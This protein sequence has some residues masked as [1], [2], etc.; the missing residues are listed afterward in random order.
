LT[1]SYPTA[2]DTW[3]VALVVAALVVPWILIL[4]DDDVQPVPTSM[5]L[6]LGGTTVLVVA[7]LRFFAWPVRYTIDD[8]VLIVR[9]GWIRYRIVLGSIVRVERSRSPV[10]SPAWSLKRL[11]VIF[12]TGRNM[13]SELL[14]SPR[15]RD[16]FVAELEEACGR[17][18]T[19][20][21][22]TDSTS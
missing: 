17:P 8:D 11:R 13:N 10:S 3:L 12:R 2:Y 18:L 16:R 15:D 5:W 9:S 20:D 19:G 14:I 22:E 21:A 7:L 4:V 6:L 1:R